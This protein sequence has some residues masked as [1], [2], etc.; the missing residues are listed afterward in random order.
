MVKKVLV[1]GGLGYIGSHTCVE[2]IKSGYEVII[3]D[4]L[5]N[6]KEDVLD[7]LEKITNVRPQFY[8]YDLKEKE[9]IENIFKEN[10]IDAVIHFA[11]FKA[12][13]ESVQKPMKYYSNNL[14][15]TINLLEVMNEYN[16]KKIVFLHQLQYME[17]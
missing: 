1:T 8:K 15:S 14:T 17:M 4:D 13:G 5:S 11:G 10:E 12:V 16:V 2:L 9:K 6:S 3:V 7:R